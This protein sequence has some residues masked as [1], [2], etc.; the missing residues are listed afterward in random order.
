LAIAAAR[1]A[2]PSLVVAHGLLAQRQALRDAP[3]VESFGDQVQYLAFAI[4]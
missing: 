3:V 1:S 4:G 2:T